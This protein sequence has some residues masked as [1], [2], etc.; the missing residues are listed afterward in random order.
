MALTNNDLRK[1]KELLIENNKQIVDK[2]DKK[3]D[4]IKINQGFLLERTETIERK[5]D[6]AITRTSE[7]VERLEAEI[8]IIK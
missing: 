8:R 7:R 3:L 5:L 6:E 1:I 4:P 2:I